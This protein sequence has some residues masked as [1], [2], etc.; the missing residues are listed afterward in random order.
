MRRLRL[1]AHARAIPKHPPPRKAFL[2]EA[3]ALEAEWRATRPDGHYTTHGNKTARIIYQPLPE[4][5]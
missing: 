2:N 3:A 4:M 5:L 1:D